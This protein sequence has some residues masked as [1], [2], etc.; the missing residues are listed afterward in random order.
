MADELNNTAAS[1]DTGSADTSGSGNS[2]EA[3]AGSIDLDQYVPKSTYEELAQRL[4]TQGNELGEL[5]KFY[6]DLLP[7]L[8]KL[9]AQPGVA[10]AIL[11]GKIDSSLAQAVIEGKVTLGDAKQVS[12]AHEAV[13]KTMGDDYNKAT[14]EEI[15]KLVEAKLEAILNKKLEET[16]KK[17]EGEIQG[18]ESK[19]EFE[20]SITTFIDNTPDFE[21]F[22]DEIH[23]WLTDHPEQTDIE[24]A[25]Y[26][27]KGKIASEA[28]EKAAEEAAANAAKNIALNAGAGQSPT[29]GTV[30]GTSLIDSLVAGRPNPN[31]FGL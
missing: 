30:E 31:K 13:K 29:G 15:E 5:R 3:G 20:A 22:A 8:E 7:L 18:V 11:D 19:R 24:T 9:E 26:T 2:G 27:V 14:P 1:V 16:T 25:Y 12:K 21:D 23:Q 4:G 17:F 6:N 28:Y 10:E